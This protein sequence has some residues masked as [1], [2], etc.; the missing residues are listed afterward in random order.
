MVLDTVG[1]KP[2][3]VLKTTLDH[4]V[5]P[6]DGAGLSPKTCE[7]EPVGSSVAVSSVQF[8]SNP[9]DSAPI[10]FEHEVSLSLCVCVCK[11]K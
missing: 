6:T 1:A 8:Q 11:P 10:F 7:A 3:Y 5:V 2:Q 4:P 9:L